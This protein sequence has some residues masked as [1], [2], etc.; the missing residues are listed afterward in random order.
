M[1]KFQMDIIFACEKYSRSCGDLE[2]IFSRYRYEY[3]V[4]EASR[5]AKF[6]LLIKSG[7]CKKTRYIATETG[8][9]G[10]KEFYDKI[11]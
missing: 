6:G 8:L 4:R 5:L 3:V 9:K 2:R 10:A 7:K 1:N 11:P